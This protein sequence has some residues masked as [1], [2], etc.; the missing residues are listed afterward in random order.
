V[1]VRSA[2]S[3]PSTLS[4]FRHRV[5]LALSLASFSSNLGNAIQS[6]G[7]SWLMTSIAPRA[8]MV[9]LVQTAVSLPIMLFALLG[10]AIA[11]LFDRRRVMLAAQTMMASVSILLAMLSFAGLVTPWLLLAATFALGM[12]VAMFSP[13]MQVTVGEVVP[14]AELAGAV[15]LNIL[16]FNVARSRITR[17]GAVTAT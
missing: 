5:F 10:G 1:T 6:V 11:D 13:A 8:D 17:I 3:R 12:G 16:G 7:A 15:S 4:P 9:A 14:R 2:P